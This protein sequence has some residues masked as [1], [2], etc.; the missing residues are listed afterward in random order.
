MSPL[1]A[2]APGLLAA[3]LLAAPAWADP[4]PAVDV[5]VLG[6]GALAAGRLADGDGAPD[7]RRVAAVVRR[8]RAAL[9]RCEGTSPASGRLD[10]A[11]T[12]QADGRVGEVVRALGPLRDTALAACAAAVVRALVFPR[13]EGG[14][15]AVGVS[16]RFLAG[17]QRVSAR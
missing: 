14:R 16:L 2:T 17:A 10:L 15:V 12:L 3:A 1:R 8:S 7:A 4:P 9:L 6:A 5:L 11:F 13:P